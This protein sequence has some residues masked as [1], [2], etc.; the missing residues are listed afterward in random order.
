MPKTAYIIRF[1]IATRVV[2]D[3]EDTTLV[4]EADF[5]KAIE[6]ARNNILADPTSYLNGDNCEDT[7]EDE[8]V[9]YNPETDD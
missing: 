3:V 1:H 8:E 7:E 4:D 2:L 9:P 6:A 5:N